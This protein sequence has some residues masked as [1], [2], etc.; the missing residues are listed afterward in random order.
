MIEDSALIQATGGLWELGVLFPIFNPNMERF[1]L[2]LTL[3]REAKNGLK[4][5]YVE[6]LSDFANIPKN[7][8]IFIG[9]STDQTRDISANLIYYDNYESFYIDHIAQVFNEGYLIFLKPLNNQSSASLQNNYL[10]GDAIT[11]RSVARNWRPIINSDFSGINVGMSNDFYYSR[12]DSLDNDKGFSQCIKALKA[13]LNISDKGIIQEVSKTHRSL[14][15]RLEG[16]YVRISSWIKVNLIEQDIT[17][18]DDI[19]EIIAGPQGED[20]DEGTA[21]MDHS[22]FNKTHELSAADTD[23]IT[24]YIRAVFYD[25]PD[26][27]SLLLDDSSENTDALDQSTLNTFISKVIQIPANSLSAKFGIYAKFSNNPRMKDARFF[28]DDAVI[29]HCVGTSKE[30]N[31]YYQMDM[32][33]YFDMTVKNGTSIGTYKSL[34]GNI[35]KEGSGDPSQRLIITANWKN[36]PGYFIDDMKTLEEWNNQGYPI[37]LRTKMTGKLPYTLFCNMKVSA[38]DYL[39]GSGVQK[40]DVSIEFEEISV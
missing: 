4:Y 23:Y 39:A 6:D 36:R 12:E 29:E 15:S 18:D 40:A 37:V 17:I 10:A 31:G 19:D 21:I 30:A 27:S 24:A 35:K 38:P 7:S 9:P 28:I 8:L 11:I 32:N 16:H 26:N 33:P 22:S 34:L 14:L 1:E 2:H 3:S 5:I 25:G 13:P 20:I